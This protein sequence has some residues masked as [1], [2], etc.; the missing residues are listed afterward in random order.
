LGEKRFINFISPIVPPVAHAMITG[1]KI[2][3]FNN[4][5]LLTTFHKE[6]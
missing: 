2:K 3:F 1:T 5:T 6:K 4:P